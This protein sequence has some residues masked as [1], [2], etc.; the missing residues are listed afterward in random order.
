MTSVYVQGS[1]TTASTTKKAR[2]IEAAARPLYDLTAETVYGVASNFPTMVRGDFEP[3]GNP[4]GGTPCMRN[5]DRT[6][7]RRSRLG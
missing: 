5:R 6:I 4:P 3:A 2:A 1:I 7:L